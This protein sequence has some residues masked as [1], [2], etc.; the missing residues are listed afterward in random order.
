MRARHVGSTD[1]QPGTAITP[2]CVRGGCGHFPRPLKHCANSLEAIL[3]LFDADVPCASVGLQRDRRSKSR[4]LTHAHRLSHAAAACVRVVRRAETPAHYPE[5]VA[6]LRHERSVWYAVNAAL[7]FD[8]APDGFF[9]AGGALSVI[10]DGGSAK[11]YL[12]VEL[13]A[14]D[15]VFLRQSILA[16]HAPSLAHAD[17]MGE[18]DDL[19]LLVAWN[20]IAQEVLVNE[21][22]PTAFDFRG[23]ELLRVRRV[24]VADADCN[25][26]DAALLHHRMGAALL[27]G[28]RMAV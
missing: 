26:R 8:V 23:G 24:G 11:C 18:P 4:R 1:R 9:L 22:L 7:M 16:V 5:L 20:H 13:L 14:A 3:Q 10:F 27:A 15:A 21:R 12:V 17:V 28:Q 19:R 25:G 2:P 6:A